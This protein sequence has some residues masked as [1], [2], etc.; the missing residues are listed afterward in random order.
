MDKSFIP[1]DKTIPELFEKI[2]FLEKVRE[3][4]LSL[5]EKLPEENIVIIDG[6]KS[7]GEV[8]ESIK[9]EVDKLF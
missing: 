1:A 7:V 9:Y 5:K 6:S 3:N 4:Y 2:E 8:F